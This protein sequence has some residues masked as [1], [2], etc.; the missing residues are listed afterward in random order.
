MSHFQADAL[1]NSS[2]GDL[3]L[4]VGSLSRIVLDAAGQDAQDECLLNFP[5]GL[6][7]GQVGVTSSG[8]LQ[9]RFKAIFHVVLPK[10]N[11]GNGEMVT[12]SIIQLS[13]KIIEIKNNV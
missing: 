5:C 10:W 12:L 2:N 11:S 9:D 1:V 6:Q 7:I 13:R 4:H 8:K 3:N